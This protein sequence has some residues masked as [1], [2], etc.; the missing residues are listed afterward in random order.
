MS[1]KE[2]RKRRSK[3]KR[4]RR[5]RSR[6]RS[7]SWSD[8]SRS[9]SHSYSRRRTHSRSS[10]YSRS[11]RRSYRSRSRSRDRHNRR[12]YSRSPYRSYRSRSRDRNRRRS[13]R[14]RYRNRS[15]SRSPRRTYRRERSTSPL[16]D[17]RRHVGSRDN[18]AENCCIGV[19]GLSLY[20]TEADLRE[21]YTVYGPLERCEVV[22]DHKTG[23]SRGFAFVTFQNVD[24]ARDAK[25][26]TDG[27]DIDGRRIRVDFSITKRAHTPTPGIYMG[28]PT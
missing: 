20:T 16:S 9:R 22:Y 21:V 4:S 10:S 5:S 2:E 8:R 24:D 6:S 3:H 7:P 17:R 18:P 15:L 12:S 28:Q 27:M 11:P 14:D 1:D 19:F 23:R 25:I 26:R 13:Y